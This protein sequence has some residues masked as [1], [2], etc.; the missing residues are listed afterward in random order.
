[1][2]LASSIK[3]TKKRAAGWAVAGAM[4]AG[5]AAGWTGRVDA[6]EHRPAARAIPN[7]ELLLFVEFDGLKDHQQAWRQT[8]AHKI[9]TETS[10]GEMLGELVRQI[11]KAFP[12]AGGQQGQ[13]PLSGQD[14]TALIRHVIRH[15]FAVGLSG[16]PGQSPPRGVVVVPAVDQSEIGKKIVA[17]L[18]RQARER[19]AEILRR[20]DRV[21]AVIPISESESVAYW[22][23]QG[24]LVAAVGPNGKVVDQV[25]ATLTG[26]AA[27]VLKNPIR[28]RLLEKGSTGAESVARGFVNLKPLLAQLPPEARD[29]GLES[30]EHAE[31]NWGFQGEAVV[32]TLHLRVPGPR[33]GVLAFLNQPTF[34]LSTLPPLPS[35]LREF[36]VAS[37]DLGKFLDAVAELPQGREMIEK[38]QDSVQEATGMNLRQDILSAFGPKMA[39][40]MVPETMRRS[41]NPYASFMDWILHPPKFTLL[42]EVRDPKKFERAVAKMMDGVN[43]LLREQLA[44]NQEP[45]EFIKR[46][47]GGYELVVPAAVMPMP[48]SLRPTLHIGENY[49]VLATSPELARQALEQKFQPADLA[50][51]GPVPRNLWSLT[52]ND[53]RTSVP[54]LIP[55]LPFFVQ[56]LGRLAMEQDEIRPL[57][58]LT[59]VKIDPDSIPRPEAIEKLLFPGWYAT[60]VDADGVTLTSREWAPVM[61]PTTAA[62]VLVALLL[63][64]VQ[65]ARE[66][67]RRAQ[68]TNNLKQMALAMHNFASATDHFPPQ[69]IRSRDG[70]PLLS[71]RVAILPYLEQNALYNEF[72]LDEPWDSP[73]NRALAERMPNLYA[74]PSKLLPPGMTCYQVPFGPGTIF[75]EEKGCRLAQITDGTSNTILIVEVQEPVLWTKPDDLT[76]DPKAVDVAPAVGSAHPGGWNAAF[77]DGSVRFIKNTIELNV[78]RAVLTRDGG[79]IV[80]IP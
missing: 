31:M 7:E 67:A 42:M 61:S 4:L 62:P 1:M 10:T 73:H 17:L 78:L 49:A 32:S 51:L 40:Y 69:A 74:C 3:T 37:L 25:V 52:V 26:E 57:A 58:A 2:S 76:Y 72:H 14:L 20:D 80:N 35:G 50:A 34:D 47:H 29:I 48:A 28:S 77:A 53:P 16:L 9:L 59:Q 71:W 33:K 8:A 70:K 44:A 55:N 38:L 60:S 54:E 56:A 45:V 21:I 12:E 36:S 39:F 30:I 5:L 13:S 11:A 22:E 79:E 27:S 43:R 18:R 41:A 46:P 15:G 64:A 63:P 19:K 66:A 68:C 65:S 24:D 6:Q 23:E 75:G